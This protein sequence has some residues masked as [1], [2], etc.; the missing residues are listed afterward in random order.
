MKDEWFIAQF[1]DI[2]TRLARI[3]A[4]ADQTNGNVI[5]NKAYIDANCHKIRLMEDFHLVRQT[6][7][8]FHKKHPKILAGGVSIGGVSLLTLIGLIVKV[9]IDLGVLG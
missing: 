2:T 1:Q 9:L 4:K 6:E 7:D 5:S 3:E 8:K